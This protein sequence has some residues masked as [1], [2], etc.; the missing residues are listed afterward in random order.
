MTAAPCLHIAA[1]LLLA[2]L[3]PGVVNRTKAAFAGRRGPPLLQLYFDLAKLLCKG[4]VY[5][6][7]ATW[8]FRAAPSITL[9]ALLIA[10]TL[11][12][13]PGAPALVSFG[14]SLFLFVSLLGLARLATMLAA[15][16]TGS[17]FA[18]MG[19]SREAQYGA[20]SEPAILLVLAAFAQTSGTLSLSRLFEGVTPAL[21]HASGP[22]LGLLGAALLIVLLVENC[23]I[24]FDDPETHLELTMIH[25]AMVLDYGG[26]DLAFV[27][28]GAAL[29]LWLFGALLVNLVLPLRPAHPTAG[30][31]LLIAGLLATAVA[32]GVIES[33]MARLRLLKV[34]LLVLGASAL[35]ALGLA[36]LLRS[37]A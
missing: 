23:R 1:A 30:V 4:A 5:S 21:W 34:P 27:L 25:E 26:P 8:V 36:L 17:S 7:T 18:G 13:V 35:A 28:Y 29:K 20:L 19:A 11:V 15:L 12:P 32:V 2:P 22:A 6:R 14:G 37:V 10:L 16:D 33:C 31:G 24:P 9:A 3:L